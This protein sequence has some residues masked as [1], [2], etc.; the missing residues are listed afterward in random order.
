M[1]S[2]LT[3]FNGES[4]LDDEIILMALICGLDDGNINELKL[5][6]GDNMI[7]Y[8]SLQYTIFSVLN[9]KHLHLFELADSDDGKG[10]PLI[11]FKQHINPFYIMKN[12]K[13]MLINK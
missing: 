6:Y 13:D 7:Q 12:Y 1:T 4:V 9:E 2:Y 11:K 10:Q 5:K 3:Y 8:D